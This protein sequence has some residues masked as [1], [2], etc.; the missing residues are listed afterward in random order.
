ML[1]RL[2]VDMVIDCQ[3]FNQNA[4]EFLEARL[5]LGIHQIRGR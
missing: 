1:K 3:R 5:N 2:E 4:I